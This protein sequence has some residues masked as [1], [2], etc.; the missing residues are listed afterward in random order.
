MNG[1]EAGVSCCHIDEVLSFHMDDF[2][3][4][5][6]W[7]AWS[8]DVQDSCQDSCHDWQNACYR[9]TWKNNNINPA[10]LNS[11]QIIDQLAKVKMG[12]G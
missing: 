8:Y 1:E 5:S 3:D 7:K 4:G 11:I 10:R 6:A 2:Y 9:Q 12:A